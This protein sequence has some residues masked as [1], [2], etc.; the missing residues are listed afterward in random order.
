[1]P[2]LTNTQRANLVNKSFGVVQK[3]VGI[4][5]PAQ[6]GSLQFNTF[7]QQYLKQRTGKGPAKSFVSKYDKSLLKSLILLTKGAMGKLT[8]GKVSLEKKD[9]IP[10]IQVL[11]K[12]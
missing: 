9:L 6:F 7:N 5:I 4:G 3:V 11:T 8:I 2:K 1:M 12:R 10:M